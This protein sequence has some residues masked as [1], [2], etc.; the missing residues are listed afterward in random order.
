V[1]RRLPL[2]LPALLCACIDPLSEDDVPPQDILFDFD[3]ANDER[4]WARGELAETIDEHD[5]VE[6][7]VVARLSA[8]SGGQRVWYW[9]FGPSPTFAAPLWVLV[10]PFAEGEEFVP[11]DHPLIWDVVP[12]DAAYSP[13]W[14]LHV[15]SVTDKYA[16]ERLTSRRAIDEALRLGLILPPQPSELYANCPVIGEHVRMQIRPG[17]FP[18]WE[19]EPCP[20]DENATCIAP[21]WAYCKGVRVAYFDTNGPRAIDPD[22]T[23]PVET[24]YELRRETESL[25]LS[26]PVRGVDITG[27]EDAVD[28]NDVLPTTPC[29]DAYT[30]VHRTTEVFVT[31]TYASI[32]TASDETQADARNVR[33]LFNA[34]GSPRTVLVRGLEERE[35]WRNL[36]VENLAECPE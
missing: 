30:P 36:A 16:G 27:D 3:P 34:N 29:D 22:G 33:D 20:G 6:G 28:T 10:N 18:G 23:L 12:G 26:E 2:L 8:F 15:V 13:Y 5:A 31:G 17:T 25:P 14:R 1:T 24:V 21:H 32:D 7:G 4:P 35:G 19:E 9:D 11:I